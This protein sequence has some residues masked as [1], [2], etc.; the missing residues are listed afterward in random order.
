MA[1]TRVEER[2]LASLGALGAAAIRPE[3]ADDVTNAGVLCALPALLELG[4]LRHSSE[5]FE[6][7]P[8]FYP[9]ETI[10][11]TMAF[12]ALVR[13]SSLESLRYV[14]QGDWGKILGLDRIPEVKT[15]RRKLEELTA[16]IRQS[17]SAECGPCASPL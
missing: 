11:L 1:T 14:S 10:F 6:M 2:V 16:D 8:G 7:R 13:V 3:R 17:S 4:L 12:L 15:M 9:L 5:H